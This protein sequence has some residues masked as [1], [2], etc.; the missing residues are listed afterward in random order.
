M[1]IKANLIKHIGIFGPPKLIRSDNEP[2][3]IEAVTTI[4]DACGIDW[5]KTTAAYCPSH[6]GLVERAVQTVGLALRKLAEINRQAWTDW[7]QLVSLAYN[8]RI[9]TTT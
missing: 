8:S 6:N 5:H 4:K 9:H 1:Q 3:L 7:L 2:G